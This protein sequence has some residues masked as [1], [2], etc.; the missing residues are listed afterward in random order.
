MLMGD[1]RAEGLLRAIDPAVRAGLTG[2]QED[3]IRAAARADSWIRHP[4]DLRLSLPTPFGQLYLALVA[5]RERRSTARLA[6]ERG[7][8]R[9][10]LVGAGNLAAVSVSIAVVALAGLAIYGILAGATLP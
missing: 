10:P 5:G 8:G 7:R 1:V 9:H 6:I 4:I 3:A 2:R